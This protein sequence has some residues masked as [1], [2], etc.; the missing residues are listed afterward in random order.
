MK[1]SEVIVG[2][3]NASGM[4][5]HAPKGTALPEGPFAVIP[6]AWKKVG[7]VTSDGINLSTDKSTEDLKNWANK[8]KRTIL[9]DHS[10][11]VE[12][13]I[14]DTTEESLKTVFGEDNVT[15]KAATATAGKSISVNISAEELPDEEAYLFLMKDG[16]AGVMLGTEDGQITSLGDVAFQPGAGIT[17][18]PTIKGIDSGWKMIVDDG[19]KT[20]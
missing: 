11:V 6:E 5:Y 19:V 17:W 14:M 8:V 16:D 3:G 9:S 4:F 15:V 20:A 18:T 10:E 13:P 2:T 12:V 1:M 7:D